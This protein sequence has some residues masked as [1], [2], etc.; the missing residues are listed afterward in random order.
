MVRTVFL[1]AF[2]TR[3]LCLTEKQ[4]DKGAVSQLHFPPSLRVTIS[5]EKRREMKF[6]Q[7]VGDEEENN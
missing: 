2:D 4:L 5:S 7:K 3:V 6:M 1:T